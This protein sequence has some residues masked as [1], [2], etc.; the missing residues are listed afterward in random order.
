MPIIQK[1]VRC[2]G[3][4]IILWLPFMATAAEFPAKP[5]TVIVPFAAG[6]GSDTFVRIFQKAIREHN[7]SPQPIVIR[8][9]A[10]AG[11]TIRTR[12]AHDAKP[13]G[14]TKL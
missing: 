7:L 3:A 13:E 6:G 11:G 2:I 1:L 14:Y 5:I 8:N 12:A 4:G 9:I 10:G